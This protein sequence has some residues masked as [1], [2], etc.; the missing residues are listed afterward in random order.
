MTSKPPKLKM[1][2]ARNKETY[3]NERIGISDDQGRPN[4]KFI[5]AYTIRGELARVNTKGFLVS[6]LE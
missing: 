1:K 6:H 3:R 5:V 2:N 4:I